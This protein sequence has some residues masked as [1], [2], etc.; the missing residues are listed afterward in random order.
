MVTD[1]PM[2]QVK[3]AQAMLKENRKKRKK[4]NS[5]SY[6]AHVIKTQETQF[7]LHL[8]IFSSIFLFAEISVNHFKSFFTLKHAAPHAG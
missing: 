7:E 4:T 1:A 6:S 5:P 2:Q 8:T 3:D